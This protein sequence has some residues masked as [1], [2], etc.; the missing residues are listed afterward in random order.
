[1]GRRILVGYASYALVFLIFGVSGPAAEDAA[2]PKPIDSDYRKLDGLLSVLRSRNTQQ[3]AIPS[4][5][6]VDEASYVP[7]GDIDQWVTIRGW[8]R[9]NPV[10]VFLHG[11]PGD[12]TNPWTFALFA[13]WEKHFTVVQW[14]QRGAGRTLRK[15]GPAVA[16]TIT[17]SRLVADGIELSEYLCKHLHKEKIIIVAHSLGSLIGLKM[18]RAKPELF[19][20]YVGTGQVADNAKN[21]SVAYDELLKKA[22]AVGNQDAIAELTRV[23]PPP[24]K[25]GEGYGVQRRWA[26]A[27]EGADQFLFGTLGLTLVAPGNSVQDIDDS[28]DGQKLSAEQ[29][30]PQTKSIGPQQLGREFSLPI[31]IFQGAEDF[32]TPTALARSYFDSIK[33]PRKAFVPIRGGGHFA[34]FMNSE[35]FLRELVGRVRPLAVRR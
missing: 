4:A 1:M 27:F 31:F 10:L 35:Q 13:P 11:G 33:A 28:V 3:F 22:R 24:Y 12:V 30:V 25:T 26:N 2:Q 9:D 32:T 6:G 20:A 18:A 14:D 15:S 8:D 34:V 17:L 5:K 19:H 16:P 23:G 29:L 7:I 21:Y